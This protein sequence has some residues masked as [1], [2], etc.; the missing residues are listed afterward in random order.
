MPI[1]NLTVLLLNMAIGEMRDANLSPNTI[2]SYLC[3]FAAF[4]HWCKE[5]DY[6]NIEV[7]PYKGEDTVKDVYTDAV[8][9]L[10]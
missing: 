7:K 8:C 4:M 3:V 6:P 1:S 2:K 10:S 5:N 9:K